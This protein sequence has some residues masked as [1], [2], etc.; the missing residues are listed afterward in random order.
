M[1]IRVIKNLTLGHLYYVYC[2][3]L[4]LL[5][6]H[7]EIEPAPVVLV[8]DDHAVVDHAEPQYVVLWLERVLDHVA[9][10]QHHVKHYH[11]HTHEHED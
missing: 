10:T 3:V 6:Y 9:L 2:R 5:F 4:F 7:L 11:L 8:V 1:T